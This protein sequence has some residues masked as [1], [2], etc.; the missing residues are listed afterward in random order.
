MK[1]SS[2]VLLTA[3]FLACVASANAAEEPPASNESYDIRDTIC[4]RKDKHIIDKSGSIIK[5]AQTG[6]DVDDGSD[7]DS[8]GYAD[9]TGAIDYDD[10]EMYATEITD[11]TGAGGIRTGGFGNIALRTGWFSGHS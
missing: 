6:N 9:T 10:R 5:E 3:F 1:K 8:D 4:H 7:D 2:N 11:S